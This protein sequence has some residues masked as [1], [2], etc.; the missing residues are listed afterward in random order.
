MHVKKVDG[1]ARFVAIEYAFL[2]DLHSE[3]VAGGVDDRRANAAARALARDQK[4]VD[5]Q[6][7]EFGNQRSAPKRAGCGLA[8]DH[9]ALLRRDLLDD[10]ESSGKAL[11]RSGIAQVNTAR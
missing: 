5:P 9:V 10:V 1:V 7:D 2:N 4:R 8:D 11:A 6:T 3:P